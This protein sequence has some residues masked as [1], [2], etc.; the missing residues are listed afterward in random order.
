MKKSLVSFLRIFKK[1]V[2][3]H[4]RVKNS[5]LLFWYVTE[6]KI[7]DFFRHFFLYPL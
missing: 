4:I 6:K 2:L 7:S 5:N 3:E 1:C